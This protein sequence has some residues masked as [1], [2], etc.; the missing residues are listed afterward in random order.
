MIFCSYQ[1]LFILKEEYI[2]LVGSGGQELLGK[3]WKAIYVTDA[4][5]HVQPEREMQQGGH[6]GML[7][8]V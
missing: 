3:Y 1:L 8:T 6:M 7:T 4:L 5:G 2:A